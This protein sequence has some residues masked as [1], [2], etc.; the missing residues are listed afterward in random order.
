[1]VFDL[2][3][4]DL[5]GLRNI[6]GLSI[7][8]TFVTEINRINDRPRTTGTDCPHHLS[9]VESF[10]SGSRLDRA[11]DDARSPVTIGSQVEATFTVVAI[12]KNVHVAQEWYDDELFCSIKR[13]SEVFVMLAP[14]RALHGID[15]QTIDAKIV[16]LEAES[17]F[18]ERHG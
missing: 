10:L 18:A 15:V 8:F 13:E 12:A 1:M 2:H 17:D 4:K 11:W 9:S 14:L 5:S 6:D 7:W 3:Q 16:E